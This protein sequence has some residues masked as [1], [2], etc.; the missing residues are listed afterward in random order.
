MGDGQAETP[1]V[2]L[3]VLVCTAALVEAEPGDHFG[4]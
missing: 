4:I 2:Q 3:D 1:N